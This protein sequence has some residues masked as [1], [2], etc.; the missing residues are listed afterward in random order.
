MSVCTSAGGPAALDFPEVLK[1]LLEYSL[2]WTT[3]MTG[4]T[5]GVLTGLVLFLL[6]LQGEKGTE[7][8]SLQA[9]QGCASSDPNWAGECRD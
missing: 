2:P 3:K 8:C 4:R 1:S 5:E 6:K 9:F 7:V